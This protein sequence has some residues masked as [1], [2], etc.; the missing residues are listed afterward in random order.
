M[1]PK[2]YRREI[3]RAVRA[4]DKFCIVLEL[5]QCDVEANIVELVRRAIKIYTDKSRTRSSVMSTTNLLTV[6]LSESSDDPIPNCSIYFN[7]HS[8]YVEM[9]KDQAKEKEKAK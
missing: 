3:R 4:Y 7:L 8:H 2:D 5:P 6:Q 9:A 1:T